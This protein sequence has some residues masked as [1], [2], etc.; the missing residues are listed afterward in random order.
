VAPKFRNRISKQPMRS[1]VMEGRGL[2]FFLVGVGLGG[3]RE[4]C[5]FFSQVVF[6]VDSG[7]SPLFTFHLVDS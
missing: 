6:G 1:H 4:I 7:L 2:P 3:G 5:F